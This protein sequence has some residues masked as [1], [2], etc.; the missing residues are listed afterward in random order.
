LGINRVTGNLVITGNFAMNYKDYP[1]LA[2]QML[3]Q[4]LNAASWNSAVA[5]RYLKNLPKGTAL[6][7][8]CAGSVQVEA[9]LYP[10]LPFW[11]P[12]SRPNKSC[13]YVIVHYPGSNHQ[14]DEHLQ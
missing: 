7:R 12:Y 6:P 5:T 10:K 2:G 4:G 1:S 9:E 14:R 11:L 8:M 13:Y 3:K